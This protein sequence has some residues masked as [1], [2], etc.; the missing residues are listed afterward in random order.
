LEAKLKAIT[1]AVGEADKKRA[2]EVAATKLA[3]DW[4]VKEAEARATKVEKSLAK[5]SKKQSQCKEA[6]VKRIDDLLNAFDSK[7]RLIVS[8]LVFPIL[9]ICSQW[10]LFCDAAEQLGEVI[11]LRAGD[12]K[13]P[14][15][16]VV[17]LL[18]SNFRIFK[19]V[20]QHT[21]HVLPRLFA[22]LFPKKR[23]EMPTSNLRKLVEAFDTLKDPTL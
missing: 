8:S 21:R 20:L 15:L 1:Q 16:D 9:F 17:G 18:E 7:Y 10:L 4:A 14:L 6:A 2:E 12:A 11:R 22:G 19:S 23:K 3:A 5:I 13:A